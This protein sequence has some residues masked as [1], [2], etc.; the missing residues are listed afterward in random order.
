M[1][2]SKSDL[3]SE[4][5]SQARQRG[6]LEL[7]LHP[8]VPKARLGSAL[9]GD[10]RE[11]LAR[12]RTANGAGEALFSVG[13]TSCGRREGVTSVAAGLA[14]LASEKMR[15][16]LVDANVGNPQAR[17]RLGIAVAHEAP[18]EENGRRE[19]LAAFLAVE[20]LPSLLKQPSGRGCISADQSHRLIES[21]RRRFDLAIFD[22]PALSEDE[23]ALD[24]AQ[25]LDGVALVIASERVRWRAARKNLDLLRQAEARVI[26]TVLNR[27]RIYLPQWLDRRI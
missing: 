25:V 26:G 16:V 22:L 20:E 4:I 13:F 6:A 27:R 12:V 5:E 7:R 17:S 8:C 11:L 10:F 23:T 9:R 1:I 24:W 21:L 18:A 2:S 19:S 15:V 14:L 3:T